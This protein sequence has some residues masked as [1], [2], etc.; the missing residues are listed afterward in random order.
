MSMSRAGSFLPLT[1]MSFS[2]RKAGNVRLAVG[3]E[4]LFCSMP[5]ENRSVVGESVKAG[6]EKEENSSAGRFCG[7]RK[8]PGFL[9]FF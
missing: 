2:L 1:P 8:A 9:V 5:V 6:D 3:E 4:I 7:R